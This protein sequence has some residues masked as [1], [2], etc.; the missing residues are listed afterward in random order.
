MSPRRSPLDQETSLLKHSLN[1]GCQTRD[2]SGMTLRQVSSTK[3]P[4]IMI[5]FEDFLW[6]QGLLRPPAN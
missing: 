6:L 5:K 1:Q 4:Q 2:P 3:C